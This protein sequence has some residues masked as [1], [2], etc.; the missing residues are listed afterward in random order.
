MVFHLGKL[1]NSNWYVTETFCL[2]R[3][4]GNSTHKPHNALTMEDKQHLVQFLHNYAKVNAILLPRRL[5]G[6]KKLDVQLLPSN[7]TKRSVWEKYSIATGTSSVRIV[8]FSA[9]CKLR[10][11]YVPQILITKPRS[12]LCW[13]CQ[14]NSTALII[15][16]YST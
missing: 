13:V 11:Q 10:K 16:Y 7:T 14:K 5:P 3:T 9:F 8:G 1:I 2:F 6:Y 12:D 15:W 4:H